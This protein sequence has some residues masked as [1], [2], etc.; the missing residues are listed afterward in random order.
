MTTHKSDAV[1]AGIMPDWAQAGV[2]LNRSTEYTVSDSSLVSGDTLQL[3]PV[4]K[5]A[6]ILRI[7]LFHNACPAGVTGSDLGYGGDTNAFFGSLTL[8]GEK[9]EIYPGQ[10]QNAHTTVYFGK[11][12]GFLHT[13]TADDTIDL[14]FPSAPTHI[15]TN[16]D[17]K[18][19]VWYKM[20]GTIADET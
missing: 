4:P 2:V 17:F 5:G 6:K 8:T 7:E 15:V 19:S 9:F 12:D 20:T 3:I 18:I 14:T 11:T 1:Q 13:F 10:Q 16:T